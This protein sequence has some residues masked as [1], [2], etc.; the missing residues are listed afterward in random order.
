VRGKAALRAQW[1]QIWNYLEKMAFFTETVVI[2]VTQD[3]ASARCYC[4]EIMTTK[5]GTVRRVVGVYRDELIRTNGSWLFARREYE[6][7]MDEGQTA[8]PSKA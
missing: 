4:H 2:S 1:E 3:R 6:L 7:F 5:A 8:A